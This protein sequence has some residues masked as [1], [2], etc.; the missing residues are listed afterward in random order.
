MHTDF[1]LISPEMGL[2]SPLKSNPLIS[3]GHLNEV[4]HSLGFANLLSDTVN[5]IVNTFVLFLDL[6][7]DIVSLRIDIGQLCHY[8][9]S[10]YDFHITHTFVAVWV[11]LVL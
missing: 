3:E 9:L 10:Y 6:S 2:L 11:L 5:N 4:G 7:N 1:L 8:D